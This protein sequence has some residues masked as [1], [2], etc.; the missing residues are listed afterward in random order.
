VLLAPNALRAGM[1]GVP[2]LRI[3]SGIDHDPLPEADGPSVHLYRPGEKITRLLPGHFQVQQA[4]GYRMVQIAAGSHFNEDI[5]RDGSGDWGPLD[6]NL[7]TIAE[8]G[9]DVL[10]VSGFYWMPPWMKED[11]NVVALRCLRHDR[12]V[13]ILSIWSSYTLQ[14]IDRC[15][16]V[17]A[18]HLENSPA[19]IAALSAMICGDFGEAIFPAGMVNVLPGETPKVGEREL[20]SHSGFWCNDLAAR[21]SYFEFLRTKANADL[22]DV[23][24]PD[25]FPSPATD[26]EAAS[27]WLGFLDWYHDSMT[28]FAGD[29]L[30]IYRKHFPDPDLVIWLG[31]GVE[32]HAH[33][34]DNSALPKM[35]KGVRGTI[36]GT[37]SGSQLLYRKL[38]DPSQ[39]LA[40]AFQ[41]NH[42][43]VRRVGTA[44]KFY[45]VPYWLEQPYP[46]GMNEAEIVTRVFE[47]ASCGAAA[48]FEW[49]R[50]LERHGSVYE[51]AADFLVTA[52]PRVD[53][54][55]YFPQSTHR[56]RPDSILPEGYWDGAAHLRGVTDYDV[57]DD[58]LIRDGALANYAMLV[59]VEA[60]H[61]PPD[62][63]EDLG[64]WK[65]EGGV[66]VVEDA[67]GHEIDWARIG[68]STGSGQVITVAQNSDAESTISN[69]VRDQ[70][71]NAAPGSMDAGKIAAGWMDSNGSV[72]ATGFDE[73]VL[74][75]NLSDET[76]TVEYEDQ[77][78][79]L[80]PISIEYV[81][82]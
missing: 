50:M 71:R 5:E 31:G 77:S 62:V 32:P 19:R 47:A 54:A 26:G 38:E 15:V 51:W 66:L 44:C 76:V 22:P 23:S 55:V 42:P 12:A 63:L 57:I 45:G 59:L 58:R 20:H 78:R 17:L 37:A 64:N 33:G 6:A 18:A 36:R 13:P 56:L 14:W 67:D 21:S 69:V 40:W 39:T 30:Q 75:A 53:V 48:Y 3:A 27:R 80:S 60:N 74:L 24:A 49:T 61:I 81:P 43:I 52:R 8:H 10:L 70:L 1:P 25:L 28:R 41:R 9:S 46:P 72:F 68:D 82:G 16:S 79:T 4:L 29:V 11:E 35:V 34:Q 65:R 73:G 7:R 2:M